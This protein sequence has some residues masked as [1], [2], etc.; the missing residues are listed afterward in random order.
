MF[1]K[2]QVYWKKTK[3]IIFF[4][5]FLCLPSR[6]L[7]LPRTFP[8][9]RLEP[10]PSDAQS[11]SLPPE[12][13]GAASQW[14]SNEQ[15]MVKSSLMNSLSLTSI[16]PSLTSISPS[17]AWSNHHLLI[18]TSLKSCTDCEDVDTINVLLNQLCN[19]IIRSNSRTI[20]RVQLMSS[21]HHIF[22][23]WT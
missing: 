2:T 14:W 5:F 20:V 19:L 23:I 22:L 6:P 12:A 1:S 15:M 17:L 10:F 11:R 7:L 13:V 3:K 21:A 8:F 16:S 4:F 9:S 18:W